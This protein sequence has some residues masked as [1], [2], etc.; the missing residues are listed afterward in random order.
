MYCAMRNIPCVATYDNALRRWENTT[1]IRGRS[2][3]TRPLSDRRKTHMLIEKT[4]HDGLDA[5][6]CRLYNTNV[7]TFV[8]D[9][10]VIIDNDWPSDSTNQ[11][12]TR[13]MLGASMCQKDGRTW[14]RTHS[15]MWRVD[16]GLELKQDEHGRWTPTTPHEN[17]I[18]KLDSKKWARVMAPFKP[19][20]KHA[21]NI[22]K[23][24]GGEYDGKYAPRPALIFSDMSSQDRDGWSE[25]MQ[26]LF[27]EAKVTQYSW[28]R[29]KWSTYLSV[30][31]LQKKITD[32]VKQ[33]YSEV[34]FNKELVPA[35]VYKKDSNARY[36][37]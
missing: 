11:F 6:A 24:I 7:V 33:E 12:A 36:V 13:I 1:P 20:M 31:R 37:R 25:A 23:L 10:R 15:G 18:H 9:G 21:V 4:T 22:A 32:M 14:L 30:A 2:V 35:G 5:V 17:Y 26:H 16:R 3:D 27:A 8:C 29:R 19:F 28:E 34:L